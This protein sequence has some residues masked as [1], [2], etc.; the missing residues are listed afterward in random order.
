MNVQPKES[1]GSGGE[2]RESAV[3]RTSSDL[4]VKMPVDFNLVKVKQQIEKLGGTMP[5]NVC[6]RQEVDRMQVRRG[7]CC[8]P[9]PRVI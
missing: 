4:L 1:G 6:L 7:C 8:A 9:V 2:T 5:L 3:L